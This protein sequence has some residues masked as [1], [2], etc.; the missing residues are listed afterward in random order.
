MTRLIV[1]MIAL[2]ALGACTQQA[3]SGEPEQLRYDRV[4]IE[5]DPNPQFPS[6]DCSS[7]L[8]LRNTNNIAVNVNLRRYYR[9]TGVPSQ[10]NASSVDNDPGNPHL[11]AAV[12]APAG[13]TKYLGCAVLKTPAMLCTEHRNW[14]KISVEPG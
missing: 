7:H 1:S 2:T 13:S 5:P 11:L 8:R 4:L 6:A 10:C 3:G 12:N 14:E 9:A